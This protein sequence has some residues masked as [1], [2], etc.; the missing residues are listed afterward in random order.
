MFFDIVRR[1]EQSPIV[2]VI[3]NLYTRMGD[4]KDPAQLLPACVLDT[5]LQKYR[6]GKTE[7]ILAGGIARLKPDAAAFDDDLRSRDPGGLGR[8]G[9]YQ[10][11]QVA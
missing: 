3:V 6:P 4:P 8:R 11:R 7:P 5:V 10:L 2:N 9:C 1:W